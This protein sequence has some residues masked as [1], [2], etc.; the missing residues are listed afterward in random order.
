MIPTLLGQLGT[1]IVAVING[2]A[3]TVRSLGGELGSAIGNLASAIIEAIIGGLFA[4]VGSFASNLLD[5]GKT[6]ID[7]V[8][9]FLQGDKAAVKSIDSGKKVIKDYETGAKERTPEMLKQ[10]DKIGS[11]TT[12]TLDREKDSIE[13]GEKLVTDFEKGNENKHD[14]LIES[15][16]TVGTEV[17]DKMDRKEDAEEAAENTTM[18]F[19][20]KI[21][22]LLGEFTS[23]GTAAGEAFMSGL[24]SS[25]ALDYASPSKATARAA[26]YAVQGFINTIDKENDT[27]FD[28][29]EDFGSSFLSA[30]RDSISMSE[31][32]LSSEMN[33]VISPVLDLSNIE[34]NAGL[35]SSMLRSGSTYDSALAIN[36]LRNG[37][38]NQNGGLN[39]VVVDVN[40]T[41]NNAGADIDSFDLERFGDQIADAVN[42]KLG[43]L[44]S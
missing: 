41:V 24:A 30:L 26:T 9:S 4:A 39:Q 18:G 31:E 5:F 29:G 3:D 8:T 21:Y 37:L 38:A 14:E 13:M 28:S 7:S 27:I 32:I 17:T 1:F 34:E 36:D 11:D 6:L 33:P 20:N 12:K 19:V 10:V 25:G 23:A 43:Q 16:D 42:I 15:I 2:L 40:F 44:L 35:I 22:S